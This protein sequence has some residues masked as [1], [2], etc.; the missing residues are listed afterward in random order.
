MQC[1][2]DPRLTQGA[3]GQYHCPDC[4]VMVL[5]GLPHPDICYCKGK[6]ADYRQTCNK[7][8]PGWDKNL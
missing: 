6:Y 5:A 1:K 7:C 8:S 4:E 2:H 3:I